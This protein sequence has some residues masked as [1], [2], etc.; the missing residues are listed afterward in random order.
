MFLFYLTLVVLKS[1]FSSAR[2][3]SEYINPCADPV[4]EQAVAE[5]GE[6]LYALNAFSLV[7]TA[8]MKRAKQ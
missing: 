6:A 2:P 1:L 7:F 4:G 8:P 3:R 5:S